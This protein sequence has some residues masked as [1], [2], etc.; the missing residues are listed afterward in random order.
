MTDVVDSLVV[1]LGLNADSFEAGTA[2]AGEGLASLTKKLSAFFFV[3]RGIEDVVNHFKNLSEQMFHL[4]VDS[5]NLSMAATE[6]SKWR[7]VAMLAGGD[8]EDATSS[9]QGL[10]GAIFGL[11]FQG[12]MSESLMMLQRM[13]VS[14]LTLGGHMKGVRD[15]AMDLATALARHPELNQA[16]REQYALHSGFQG[17]MANAVARGPQ[18]LAKYLETAQKDQKSLTEQQVDS[19]EALQKSLI[20]LQSSIDANSVDLLSQLTPAIIGVTNVLHEIVPLLHAIAHPIDTLMKKPIPLTNGMTLPDVGNWWGSHIYDW[21]HPATRVLRNNNPTNLKATGNQPRDAAGFAIFKNVA[22]GERAAANE[23]NLYA[24]R[25]VMTI[26]DIISRWAPS[27]DGNKTEDY[28][29]FVANQMHR[30]PDAQITAEDY[31][32]LLAAMS[33]M[34]SGIFAPRSDQISGMLAPAPPTPAAARSAPS[35]THGGKPVASTRVSIGSMSVFTQATD[36][37]GIASDMMAA[38]DRKLTV[39]NNDVALA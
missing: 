12:Q 16:E 36:A 10:Q 23:L 34:E 2:K 25:G 26:R 17:G 15:I 39:A 1:T 6:L 18:E 29:K 8:A 33:R 4:S 7:E 37:N 28:I 21:L 27:S 30:S 11:R 20:S 13:G 35:T 19:Q 32:A 14:Y 3:V 5:K 38:L 22:E 9:I 24:S 31:P